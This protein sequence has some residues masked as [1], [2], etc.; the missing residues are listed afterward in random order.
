MACEES[1]GLCKSKVVGARVPFGWSLVY[2]YMA[3]EVAYD[4]FRTRVDASLMTE[5]PQPIDIRQDV[6]QPGKIDN[7]V[8]Q[9]NAALNTRNVLRSLRERPAT[10]EEIPG[11][12]SFCGPACRA[13]PCSR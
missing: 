2:S 3:A 10:L 11:T 9:V 4:F 5:Y 7:F 12:C 1:R 13:R 6:G 8:R